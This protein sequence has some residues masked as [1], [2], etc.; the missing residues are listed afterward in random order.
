MMERDD[1]LSDDTMTSEPIEVPHSKVATLRSV[2]MDDSVYGWGAAKSYGTP[3]YG[4]RFQLERG[5][6]RLDVPIY[7]H[8][9]ILGGL[10]QRELSA[11]V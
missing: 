6:D 1:K 4:V 2:L 3:G 11:E 7:F 9:D 10:P 8:C 5:N